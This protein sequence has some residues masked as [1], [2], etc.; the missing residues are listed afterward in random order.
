MKAVAGE[1]SLHGRDMRVEDY[2]ILMENRKRGDY[3][4]CIPRNRSGGAALIP[5]TPQ[6]PVL[7]GVH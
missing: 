6:D 2:T 1:V 7:V 5:N 3:Q 4:V